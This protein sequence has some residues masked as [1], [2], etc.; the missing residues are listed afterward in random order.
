LYWLAK[1]QFL[2][3]EKIVSSAEKRKLSS[4]KKS[5]QIPR[6]GIARLRL[7]CEKKEWLILS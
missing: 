6:A 5:R 4:N 2:A 3:P 1:T 7:L